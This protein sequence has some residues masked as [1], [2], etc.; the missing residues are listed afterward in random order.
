MIQNLSRC[1]DEP[2]QSYHLKHAQPS[3]FG[4]PYGRKRKEPLGSD[5]QWHRF[6]RWRLPFQL[7][8]EQRKNRHRNHFRG[9]LLCL[10]KAFYFF[11]SLQ[12][13]PSLNYPMYEGCIEFSSVNDKAISLYNFQ[14]AEKIDSVT[15][16][17]R[18]DDDDYFW[19]EFSFK[20][21]NILDY[22]NTKSI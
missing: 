14:N 2:R 15:P 16:C 12:P 1:K 8:S 18:Y 10:A 7:H 6:L 22:F 21:V 17:K 13:P 19:K 4:L 3:D 20:C 9:F 5:T 11:A